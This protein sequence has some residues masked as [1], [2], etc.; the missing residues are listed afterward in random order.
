MNR[1]DFLI[2]S[3]ALLALPGAAFARSYVRYEAG[4]ERALLAGDKAVLLDFSATWCSTCK[5][6]ERAMNALR[7]E[8]PA[9]DEKITFV[10]VDWDTFGRSKLA[11]SL[12][13]PRRSTLVLMRGD[14]EL[15]RV[16]A[17][18]SKRD[19]KTLLDLA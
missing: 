11:N 15:G 6:Q 18:T 14:T 1:R 8:N 2:A 12:N 17:R 9:Y 19:I 13:I 5:A 16:V 10:N 4:A 3:S 7:K